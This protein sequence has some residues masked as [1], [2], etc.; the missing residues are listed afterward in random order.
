MNDFI[1]AVLCALIALIL[2]LTIE[3]QSKEIAIV[4]GIIS[5]I[6]ICSCTII[7]LQPIITFINYLQDIG[8]IDVEYIDVIL[9]CVGIGIL[10]EIVTPICV[11]AG[12][13]S[14]GKT[15]QLTAGVSVLWLGL[16]IFSKLIELIEDI[17][18]FV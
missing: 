11:D 13:A 6:M 8:N 9:R 14:L 15:L 3:K 16:P 2:Y 4:L 18:L 12:N 1:K 7:F 10:A 5:C 17:L